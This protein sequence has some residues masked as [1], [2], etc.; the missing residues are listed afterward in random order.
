MS[1][2]IFSATAVA[3]MAQPVSPS[4]PSLE[5]GNGL[6][7]TCANVRATDA[8]HSMQCHAFVHGVVVGLL[9]AADVG[10]RPRPFC[11][12]PEVTIG[13]LK[14]IVMAGLER[15]PE[16]RHHPSATL[17]TGF[18]AAAFPCRAR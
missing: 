3:I 9:S 8:A 5:D 10:R 12:P 6:Y 7:E 2:F 14:D 18:L 4:A 11:P 15:S 16:I 17:I 13:Q 1:V